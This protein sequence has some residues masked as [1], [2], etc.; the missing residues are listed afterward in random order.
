MNIKIEHRPPTVPEYQK[1]RGSTNWGAL[2]NSVV[3]TGLPNSL[4]SVCVFADNSIIGMGRIIGDGAIYFYI[5]DV[6]VLNEFRGK[7]IG[8]LIMKEMQQYMES[9]IPKTSFIGLM[10]AENTHQ[11][12]EKFGF[13]PRPAAGPGMYRPKP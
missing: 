3:A 13:K 12:Y 9:K 2:E 7:G 11:F 4:F 6:I 5:Q 1:L 8:S 10:A